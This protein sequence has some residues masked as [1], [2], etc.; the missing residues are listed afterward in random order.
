MPATRG[1]FQNGSEPSCIDTTALW[2]P[3]SA[4]GPPAR[5]RVASGLVQAV[6][7]MPSITTMPSVRLIRAPPGS[8]TRGRRRHA[9]GSRRRGRAPPRRRA[10]ALAEQVG[11][12]PEDQ[13]DHDAQQEDA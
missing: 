7:P 4:P 2:L 10:P 5:T 1:V 3:T 8:P 9:G 11:P 6:K 13:R 12:P